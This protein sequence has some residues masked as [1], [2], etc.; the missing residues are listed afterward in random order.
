MLC[1]SS[2]H[3]TNVHSRLT[4]YS[5]LVSTFSNFLSGSIPERTEEMSKWSLIYK[6]Y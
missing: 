1:G 5:V 6:S 4:R 2:S 3:L